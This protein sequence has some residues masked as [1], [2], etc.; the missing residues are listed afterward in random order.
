MVEKRT[1]RSPVVIDTD[2][3]KLLKLL[4]NEKG[5]NLKDLMEKLNISYNGLQTHI[6]R[7]INL[8]FIG[9]YTGEGKQYR[10]KRVLRTP[11]AEKFLSLMD[12]MPALMEVKDVEGGTHEFSVNQKKTKP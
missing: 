4:T 10:E 9:I 7:L 2:D 6:N 11:R 12:Y 8:G 5:I 3:I 1:S